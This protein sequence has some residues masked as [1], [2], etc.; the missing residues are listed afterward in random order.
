M[1]SPIGVAIIGSG[2]FVKEEHLPAV[3][4]SP[5]LS[6][7]AIYSR[8]H[9]SAE[10]VSES[11]SLKD[12]DLYSEDSKP[13]SELLSRKDVSAVIIA[14]PIPNQPEYIKQCLSAG[15]HV[16]AEKPI[17]KDVATAKELLA[18]YYANVD[19][20]KVFFAI[21]EQYRFMSPFNVGAQ[22]IASFGKI[23]NF[24]VRM[25][26]CIQPDM[27]YLATSWRKEPEYQG[28]FLL[29]GGVH[30]VAGMRRLLGSEGSKLERVSALT[31][32][33]QDYLPPVDTVDAI[34]R[35]VSGGQGTFSLSFGSTGTGTEWSVACEK[36]EVSISPFPGDGKGVNIRAKGEKEG[37]FEKAED[38]F[39]GVK[40]EVFAWAKSLKEGKPNPLQ[41]AEEALA[42]LE[43]LE[44][45]LRSGEKGGEGVEL[46]L[47]T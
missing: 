13:L 14:L 11:A 30:F 26:T 5:D 18:W 39:G 42:D 12:I 19:T 44:A 31:T 9:A 24:R 21:A 27:K 28:G 8:S 35:L 2:I 3:L 36:G 6:L 4:D 38:E 41:S 29:D 37:K 46:K 34:F 33:H 32:L 40:T 1:S 23:L 47:Q 16:L 15:K 7:K 45:M 22:W 10:S 25:Q 17:A 20:S 43:V